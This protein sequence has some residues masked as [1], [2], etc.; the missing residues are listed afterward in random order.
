ML[1]RSTIHE[2]TL[3][4]TYS[5][6]VTVELE[7]SG[8]TTPEQVALR[9]ADGLAYMEGVGGVDVNPLGKLDP[10]FDNCPIVTAKE[11]K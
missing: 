7:D 3:T 4:T 2:H 8:R 6:T 9:L 10:S 1:T 11:Q 5:F